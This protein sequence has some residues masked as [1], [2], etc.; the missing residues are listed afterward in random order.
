MKQFLTFVLIIC[1]FGC[2]KKDSNDAELLLLALYL[3]APKDIILEW[4]YPGS[5]NTLQNSDLVGKTSGITVTVGGQSA[6]GVAEVSSDTIQFVMPT[7]PNVNENTAVEFLIKK[8]G[9]TVFSNF[10]R[11]RPLV[12][13][14]IN[15]PVSTSRFIDGRDNKN[16]FQITATTAS[17]V[18]NTFGHTFSDLDIS[19]FTSLNGTPIPFAEKRRDGAE[20][21][22]VSLNAGTVYV[23]VRHNSGW[24]A[25]YH[26]HIAN[27]GVVPTSSA[28]LTYDGY[29]Y[30]LCYDTMGTG[31]TTANDCVAIMAVHSP[32]RSGRCTYPGDQGLT[33]RNYYSGL[34]GFTTAYSQD[35]CLNPGGGSQNEAESIFLAN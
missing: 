9:E 23:M 26:L 7:I 11:Y 17:H 1:S 3:T 28:K 25:T 32:T 24:N 31:P 22:K 34:G 29:P 27:A 12:S 4:G 30:N 18:F 13:W 15:E 33:T 21:N 10:V 5:T 14:T 2:K 6:T 19:Y 8:N 16:F 35:T 20:F